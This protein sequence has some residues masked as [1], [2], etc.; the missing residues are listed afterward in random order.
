MDYSKEIRRIREKL[1]LTQSEFAERIGV[2][3]A[4]VNRWEKGHHIPT[5]KARRKI[6][7]LCLKEGIAYHEI[8]T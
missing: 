8:E 6:K 1:L 2:S 3:Y 4:T 5:I 7:E